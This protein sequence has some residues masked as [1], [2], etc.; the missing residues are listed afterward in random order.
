MSNAQAVQSLRTLQPESGKKLA[1]SI[2]TG[3]TLSLSQARYQLI[4]TAKNSYG[5][6]FVTAPTNGAS[7]LSQST[8]ADRRLMTIP[9]GPDSGF[10]FMLNSELLGGSNY[11]VLTA[12]LV[13]QPVWRH[14]AR[15]S[16]SR[17]APPV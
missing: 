4:R 8:R 2:I 11:P 10:T 3:M 9:D 1:D 13:L 7:S 17:S 14:S 15:A 16:F 12:V 6:G 5:S